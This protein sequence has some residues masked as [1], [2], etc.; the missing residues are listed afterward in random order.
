MWPS[1]VALSHWL[2]S[3]SNLIKN[4]T[5][6]ELGAGCGLTGLVA[7]R[8]QAREVILTDFNQTVLRNLLRNVR[9]NDVVGCRVLGL[10]FYE[11]S[12]DSH[13]WKDLSGSQHRPV[14]VVVAADVICQADDAYAVAN[15]VHDCLKVGGRAVV[16]CANANHRFGVDHFR[17][18]CDRVGLNVTENRMALEDGLSEDLLKAS[19]YVPGMGMDLFQIRKVRQ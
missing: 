8:L 10:D 1:A 18:A 12:G 11:Q 9:L 5:V 13:Q 6:L 19:G 14:D 2:M 4:Q 16:V 7:A 3:N 17:T 15:T